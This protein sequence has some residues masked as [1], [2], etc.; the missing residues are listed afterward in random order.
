MRDQSFRKLIKLLILYLFAR[1][2]S[3]IW[4]FD[5]YLYFL[6]QA[7]FDKSLFKPLQ[8]SSHMSNNI[9]SSIFCPLAQGNHATENSALSVY[10]DS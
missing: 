7:Y 8:L 5:S 9:N 10:E 6:R 3:P 4:P 2:V 1:K